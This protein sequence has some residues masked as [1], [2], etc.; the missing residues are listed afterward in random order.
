MLFLCCLRDWIWNKDSFLQCL[1]HLNWKS[2]VFQN[3][4]LRK[5]NAQTTMPKKSVC[6]YLHWPLHFGCRRFNVKF[7]TSEWAAAL[8][9]ALDIS[10]TSTGTYVPVR[11]LAMKWKLGQSSQP[12]QEFLLVAAIKVHRVPYLIPSV[13]YASLQATYCKCQV[14][15]ALFLTEYCSK[16]LAF[17]LL[18]LIL[19]HWCYRECY[20]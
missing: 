4:S 11:H 10:S 12:L 17:L 2:F 14:P 5:H 1:Q 3:H 6:P 7:C 18:S 19:I 15:T 13:G 16:F 8:V 9:Q 20:L